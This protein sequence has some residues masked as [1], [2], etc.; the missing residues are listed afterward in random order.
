MSD[1]SAHRDRTCLEALHARILS[2]D[3]AAVDEFCEC[4]LPIVRRALHIRQP[5]EDDDSIETAAVE[6][7]LRHLGDPIRFNPHKASLQ[8]WLEAIASHVLQDLQRARRTVTAH[9][10]E[11]IGVARLERIEGAATEGWDRQAWID[12][13]RAVL[14]SAA[15][16]TAE[17][18]FVEARLSG[19]PRA[20]QAKALCVGHLPPAESREAMNRVWE[21]ICRR[22]RRAHRKSQ[23]EKS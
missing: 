3:T 15:R 23:C 16:T 18:A 6:A 21:L 10:I 2:G 13:H 8:T 17:R 9:E 5:C 20:E 12:R 4:A 19:A 1:E 22:A 7:A 11:G 14:L